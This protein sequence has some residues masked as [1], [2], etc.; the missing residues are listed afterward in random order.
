VAQEQQ[1]GQQQQSRWRPTRRQLLWAGGIVLAV[2]SLAV[3]TIFF[4]WQLWGVLEGYIAPKTPTEKKELVNIV[5]LIGAGIVG[6]LTA[7]AALINLSFSRRNLQNAQAALRQQADALHQER[8]LDRARHSDEALQAFFE[9]TGDLLLDKGLLNKKDNPY[10]TT[11]VTARA[12]TLAVLPQL[13][14]ERKRWLVQFLYEGQLINKDKKSLGDGTTEFEPRLVGLDG[15]DLRNANLRNLTL[16]S[17][18]LPGAILENADL[19]GANLIYSDLG[20][21][22]L[23]GADLRGANLRGASLVNADL[24]EADFGVYQYFGFYGEE[25]EKAADLTGADLPNANLT[26]AKVTKK[27][28]EQAKALEGATMPNGQKYEDWLKS[29]GPKENGKSGGSS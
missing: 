10:D 24:R 12:R 26:R 27:Q 7:I 1:D 11:R 3:V 8:D 5:V 21:T 4:F 15:A 17:A 6:A 29:K 19:R 16:Y 28:L 2:I 20:G 18:A 9:Q 22:Y 14:G 25:T 13:D 23:R